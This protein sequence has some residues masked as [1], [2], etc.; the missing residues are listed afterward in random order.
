MTA[1]EKSR[2]T[3][4]SITRD[5]EAQVLRRV[6]NSVRWD[7]L[8]G[9]IPRCPIDG[10]PGYHADETWWP[11]VDEYEANGHPGYRAEVE[12]LR[13]GGRLVDKGSSQGGDD[14]A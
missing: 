4:E 1:S 14:R 12:A 2:S 5:Q 9:D 7:V 10:A 11:C 6:L 13:I 8:V 3:T